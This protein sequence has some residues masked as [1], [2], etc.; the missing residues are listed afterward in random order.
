MAT[1]RALKRLLRVLTLEEEQAHTAL[2]SALSVLRHWEQCLQLAVDRERRGRRLLAESARNEEAVDRA[3]AL[4]ESSAGRRALAVLRPRVE[5]SE[6]EVARQRAE[7]LAKRV[8]RRQTGTLLREAEAREGLEKARRA[9]QGMDDW[10]L[11]RVQ[12]IAPDVG[13]QQESVETPRRQET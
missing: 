13:A 8:E 3:A 4:E 11:G 1:V 6:R 5:Y 7:F 9:Q 12:R 2:Q 10:Y